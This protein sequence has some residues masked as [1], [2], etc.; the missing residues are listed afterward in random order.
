MVATVIGLVDCAISNLEHHHPDFNVRLSVELLKQ[1]K[2]LHADGFGDSEDVDDILT[3]VEHPE[4]Y[5][6]GKLF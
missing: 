1:F 5:Q 6:I 3:T 2:K 4:K